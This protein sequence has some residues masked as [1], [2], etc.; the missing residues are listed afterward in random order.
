MGS[1]STRSRALLAAAALVLVTGALAHAQ[2]P[3]GN[4]L[5]QADWVNGLGGWSGGSDWRVADNMLLNDGSARNSLAVAPYR[6]PSADYIVEADVQ[7]PRGGAF[8]LWLR[9]D[10]NSGGYQA[11][12]SGDGIAIVAAPEQ[13]LV[14]L[15][16]DPE[17]DW[18]TYSFV[19]RGNKLQ[20]YADGS[21]WDEIEDNT[22]LTGTQNG[23]WSDG[24]DVSVRG[25]R[26]LAVQ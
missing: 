19:A 12:V 25:Y 10:N 3:A 9:G 21:L 13:Q 17:S 5:Y 23:L 26:V 11:L 15:E 2:V 16:W 22:Y 6:P 14:R 24:T 7:R 1:G 8:A 18:H 4:V 20:V